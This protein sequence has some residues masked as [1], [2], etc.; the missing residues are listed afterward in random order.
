MITFVTAG[1][2]EILANPQMTWSLDG[3][4]ENGHETVRVENLHHAIRL[5]K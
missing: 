1:K 2:L 5:I 3:E 4:R